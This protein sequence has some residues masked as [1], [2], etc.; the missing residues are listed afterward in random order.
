ESYDLVVAAARRETGN[1]FAGSEGDTHYTFNGQPWALSFTKPGE[2][3][4]N[5]SESTLSGLVKG[6]FRFDEDHSL[7]LSYT[8]FESRFGESM[9][10]LF[11]QQ[12]DGFRQVN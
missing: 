11:F 5:S 1:Y 4:F 12:D 8:H 6:T 10:S 3:V 7:Q 9:G 2:E